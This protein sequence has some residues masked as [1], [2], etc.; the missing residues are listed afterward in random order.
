LSIQFLIQSLERGFD[1]LERAEHT[2]FKA[3]PP[4][5]GEPPLDLV[6][7]RRSGRGPA[8][9]W[10]WSCSP[11][12]PSIGR[13]APVAVLSRPGAPVKAPITTVNWGQSLVFPLVTVQASGPPRAS[14]AR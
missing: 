5:F 4:Q 11:L 12:P 9:G 3:A 7:P 14:Q 2:A 1:L 13:F 6:D 8:Q 10:P